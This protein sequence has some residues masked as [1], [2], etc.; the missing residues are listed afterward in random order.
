MRFENLN[1]PTSP[2]QFMD[3]IGPQLEPRLEKNALVQSH[4]DIHKTWYIMIWQYT[5]RDLTKG[6]DKLPALSGLARRFSKKLG[7]DTYVA[8]LWKNDLLRG[9]GWCSGYDGRSRHRIPSIQSTPSWSWASIDCSVAHIDISYHWEQRLHQLVQILDIQTTP[10]SHNAFG[11]VSCGHLILSGV[12]KPMKVE[13]QGCSDRNI[14]MDF[15]CTI[16]PI[17]NISQ[18]RVPGQ[19]LRSTND[20]NVSR[21]DVIWDSPGLST[22]DVEVLPLSVDFIGGDRTE[23]NCTTLTVFALIL[24]PVGES[25]TTFRRIGGLTIEIRGPCY[26]PFGS[27]DLALSWLRNDGTERTVKLV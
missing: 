15:R 21:M 12:L 16:H 5:K 8:G 3:T 24:K 18:R 11:E 25:I 22:L 17:T 9:L 13:V 6:D 27:K 14:S 19:I 1:Y 23:T 4:Q 7:N 2:N 10:A 26:T 20:S